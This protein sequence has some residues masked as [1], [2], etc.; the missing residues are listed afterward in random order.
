MLNEGLKKCIDCGLYLKDC[1]YWD[2]DYRKKNPNLPKK[3]D[4]HNCDYF[5]PITK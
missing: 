1:G 2:K 5:K 3:T 4:N